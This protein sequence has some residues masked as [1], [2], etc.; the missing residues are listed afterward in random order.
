MCTG[1][2]F[3]FFSGEQCCSRPKFSGSKRSNFF[4]SFKYSRV[5]SA[6]PVTFA[7]KTALLFFKNK[8]VTKNSPAGKFLT[9]FHAENDFLATIPA[10]FE[11]ISRSNFAP[12]PFFPGA[13]PLKKEHCS[14]FCSKNTVYAHSCLAMLNSFSWRKL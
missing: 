8:Q 5:F 10:K 7:S 6:Y 9:S 1:F 2:F 12:D 3:W 14:R 11:E 4:K 13:K